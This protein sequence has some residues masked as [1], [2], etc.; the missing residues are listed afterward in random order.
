MPKNKKTKKISK[1]KKIGLAFKHILKE[2]EKVTSGKGKYKTYEDIFG[3]EKH[4]K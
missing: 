4:K 2:A 1:K 3:K